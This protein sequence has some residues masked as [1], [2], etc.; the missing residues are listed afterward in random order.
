MI[1]MEIIK[2]RVSILINKIKEMRL[3]VSDEEKIFMEEIILETMK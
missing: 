2:V 3:I 1:M